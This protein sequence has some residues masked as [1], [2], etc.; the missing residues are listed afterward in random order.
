MIPVSPVLLAAL[1]SAALA[2][3]TA[4]LF[5]PPCVTVAQAILESN[6]GQSSLF[7]DANNPFGIKF[8]YPAWGYIQKPTL[9]IL[10]GHGLRALKSAGVEILWVRKGEHGMFEV[11]TVAR[12]QT[13]PSLAEAF[14]YH[15]NLLHQPCYRRAYAAYRRAGWRGFAQAL[16]P[17]IDART[18]RPKSGQGPTYATNPAY[19]N[20]LTEIVEAYHLDDPATLKAYAGQSKKNHLKVRT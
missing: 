5:P 8:Y 4:N 18:G 10:N 2:C 1:C 17:V 6:G 12:F 20:L 19:G 7:R 14:N 15:A 11:M 16:G 13:F 3:R 9:E